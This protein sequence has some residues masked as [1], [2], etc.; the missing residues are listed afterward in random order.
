VRWRLS[1]KYEPAARALAERHY[2]RQ[3]P[4]AAGFLRPGRNYVLLTDDARA[5]WATWRGFANHAWAGAWENTLFRN[6]GAGLSSELIR[7]AIA[8]TMAAWG[9]LPSC[10]T[11][12]MID[13]DAVRRKRDPG[14][15]YRRASFEP[16]GY[17]RERRRL[18]LVL[19]VERHPAP[20][21]ALWEQEPLAM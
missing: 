5:V 2:T 12:T 18:V 21:A 15:C 20:D 8:A 1:D 3:T 14:R 7:E 19:P 9:D 16:V 10:G 6:E 4:G 13:P 17:T 11:L